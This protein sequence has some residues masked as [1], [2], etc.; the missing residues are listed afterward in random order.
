[1]PNRDEVDGSLI[2][3]SITLVIELIILML[4]VAFSLVYACV[5]IACWVLSFGESD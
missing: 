3:L 2:T 4:D 5:S 1:M